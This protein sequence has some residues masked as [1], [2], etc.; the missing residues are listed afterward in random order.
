METANRLPIVDRRIRFALV[1][2]GRISKNHLAALAE[3][4]ERA[5]IVALCDS[6]RVALA[7]P[8]LACER[9]ASLTQMLASANVDIVTLAT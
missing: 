1:G 9:Y 4:S 3:H 8:G 6:N 5:E 2:C 7:A